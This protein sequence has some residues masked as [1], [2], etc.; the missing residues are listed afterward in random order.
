M[1]F[2]NETLDIRLNKRVLILAKSQPRGVKFVFSHYCGL[3]GA[4]SAYCSA[5]NVRFLLIK[6]YL[7]TIN[8]LQ[9]KIYEIFIAVHGLKIFK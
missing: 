1:Y 7:E 9:G 8:S 4:K 6:Y 2:I 5:A 3:V